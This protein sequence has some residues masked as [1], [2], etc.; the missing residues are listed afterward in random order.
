MARNGAVDP[1]NPE[2]VSLMRFLVEGL[3]DDAAAIR[4][5]WSTRTV[6]RRLQ[7]AMDK[8]GATSRLQAGY[9]LARS[10]W[11]QGGGSSGTD[12]SS[13]FWPSVGL[14]YV[15]PAAGLFRPLSEAHREDM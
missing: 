13:P 15:D 3:T 7:S 8:L 6:R 10:G 1:P 2:E 14:S 9:L 5:G 12:R 11:L 4:L